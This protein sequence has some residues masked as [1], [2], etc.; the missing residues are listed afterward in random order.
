VD[1]AFELARFVFWNAGRG[2]SQRGDRK[3]NLLNFSTQKVE[4]WRI[5]ERFADSAELNNFMI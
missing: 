2:V 4:T 5:V 1:L 3:K